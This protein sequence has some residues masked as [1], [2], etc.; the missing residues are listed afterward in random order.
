MAQNRLAFDR[1][2]GKSRLSCF[3]ASF[4]NLD[5]W[6]RGWERKYVEHADAA[7]EECEFCHPRRISTM[8]CALSRKNLNG[9][10]R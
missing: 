10:A 6:D 3:E 5:S 2:Y 1:G 9:R 8:T 7:H 4:E